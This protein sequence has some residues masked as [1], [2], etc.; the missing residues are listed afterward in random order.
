MPLSG[1]IWD[2]NIILLGLSWLF[3]GLSKNKKSLF[4]NALY[5]NTL[6][7]KHENKKNDT[8]DGEIYKL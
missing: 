6:H 4:A 5:I 2:S 1:I 8:R 7:R 3:Y